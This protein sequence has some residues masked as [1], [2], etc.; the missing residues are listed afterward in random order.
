MRSKWEDPAGEDLDAPATLTIREVEALRRRAGFGVM[1][2]LLA[3]VAVAGLGWTLFAGPEGLA[4]IQN[5]KTRVLPIDAAG[6]DPGSTRNEPPTPAPVPSSDT[7][8]IQESALDSTNAVAPASE[9]SVESGAG[10]RLATKT[11]TR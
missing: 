2:V 7:A 4:Q 5:L 1:G 3:L 9:S 10:D 6:E 11:R 8:A